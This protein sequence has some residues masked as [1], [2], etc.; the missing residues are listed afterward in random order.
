MTCDPT[1]PVKHTTT[2]IT[3]KP[4]LETE[5]QVYVLVSYL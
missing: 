1:L 2:L 5:S 4:F 3:V